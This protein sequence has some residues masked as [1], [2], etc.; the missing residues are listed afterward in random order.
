MKQSGQRWTIKG[1]QQIVNLRVCHQSNKW[2]YV[3]QIIKNAA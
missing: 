2:E 3:T 1:A